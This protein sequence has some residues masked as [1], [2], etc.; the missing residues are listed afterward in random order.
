M[1]ELRIEAAGAAHPRTSTHSALQ[2]FQY[3]HEDEKQLV[4]LRPQGFSF[5]RLAPYTSFDDYL[6]EIERTWRSYVELAAPVL[7]RVIRLRYI[8]RILLPLAA[9][10]ID[11]DEFLKIGP[12]LP[13][14]GLVL[15]GFL[16]QQVAFEKATRHQ[17]NLV[18]TTQQPVSE[19]LPVILDI[20][21]WSEE[22]LNPRDWPKIGEVIGSLRTLKN[23]IFFNT[24]TTKCIKLLQS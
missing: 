2:A 24:L 7:V 10:S 21:V 13:Y 4:Q 18:L 22:L 1:Q 20:S 15:Y 19:K 8:N 5:N 11:L 16:T 17:V 3:L 23:R 14:E 9:S 6:P 12:K